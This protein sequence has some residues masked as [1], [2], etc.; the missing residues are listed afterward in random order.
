MNER[1][2]WQVGGWWAEIPH[3]APSEVVGFNT[4][5]SFFTPE[6]AYQWGMAQGL[7]TGTIDEGRVSGER[8]R[9]SVS[10]PLVKGLATPW[11]KEG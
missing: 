5:A 8:V 9:V 3:G 6:A 4:L 7:A 1:T 10:Y 2:V 11:A